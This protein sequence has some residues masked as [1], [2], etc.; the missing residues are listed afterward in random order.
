MSIN[1]RNYKQVTCQYLLKL[2]ENKKICSKECKCCDYEKILKQK[3]EEN[4]FFFLIKQKCG[5]KLNL[6]QKIIQS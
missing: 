2:V 4:G 5:G 3:L 1:R 6:I